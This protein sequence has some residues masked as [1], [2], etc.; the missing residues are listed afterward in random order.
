MDPGV[1]RPQQG[2]ASRLE[3]AQVRQSEQPQVRPQAAS[4]ADVREAAADQRERE[5]DVREAAADQRERE[6]DVREEHI[7]GLIEEVRGLVISAHRDALE[8]IENSLALLSASVDRFQRSEETVQRTVARSRREAAA[9]ARAAAQRD[10][11]RAY[12]SPAGQELFER[13]KTVRA[14]LSATIAAFAV[15]EDNAALIFDQLGASH[16]ERAGAYQRKA[17]QAR[18]AA[19][20]ARE[21][22]GEL[23]E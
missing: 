22:S 18:D 7:Q 17:Q 14:R 13:A 4:G 21:I 15:S 10:R 23:A 5:A 16:P 3:A 1:D 12:P 20:R 2:D 6:A 8:A 9:S 19:D 11:Q